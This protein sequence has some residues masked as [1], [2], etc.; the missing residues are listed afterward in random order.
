M[1]TILCNTPA[2]AVPCPIVPASEPEV[3]AEQSGRSIAIAK[4][5]QKDG[6]ESAHYCLFSRQADGPWR[7]AMNTVWCPINA[8]KLDKAKPLL[9]RGY[10]RKDLTELSPAEMV[11]IYKSTCG[12]PWGHEFDAE[13]GE[14]AS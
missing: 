2:V 9:I 13:T 12:L 3:L 5:W 11:G 14:V 7:P 8:D 4:W 6:K 10:S 1:N